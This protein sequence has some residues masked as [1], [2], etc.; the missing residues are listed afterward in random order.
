[1]TLGEF[2]ETN[3]VKFKEKFGDA[4]AEEAAKRLVMLKRMAE[5]P[6]S[7]HKIDPDLIYIL[8]RVVR[9]LRE[10]RAEQ[11]ENKA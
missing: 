10:E 5:Q 3:V 11:L 9:R 8:K 6:H 1:M 4:A 2:I 7:A